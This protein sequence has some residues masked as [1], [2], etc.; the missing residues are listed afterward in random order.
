MTKLINN[1]VL[2]LDSLGSPIPSEEAKLLVQTYKN[3]EGWGDNKTRSVWF[4]DIEIIQILS[5]ITANYPTGKCNG[6]RI[7]FGKYPSTTAQIKPPLTEYLGRETLV[8]VPTIDFKVLEN[9]IVR[10]V[11]QDLFDVSSPI[12]VLTEDQ[13]Y[14]HG[15]LC[16]PKTGCPT[17]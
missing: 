3:E 6:V 14:N 8:F 7:Y 13:G 9:G 15:E 4:S 16:P 11:H 1:V 10:N 5:L 2:E 12:G 17:T